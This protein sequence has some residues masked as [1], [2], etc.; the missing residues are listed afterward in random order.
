VQ[1]E[2]PADQLAQIILESL[3]SDQLHPRFNIVDSQRGIP[4]TSSLQPLLLERTTER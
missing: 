1:T 2:R 3:E 4:L